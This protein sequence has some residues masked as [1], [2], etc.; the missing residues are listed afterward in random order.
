MKIKSIILD[1]R[2]KCLSVC[3]KM[4][5]FFITNLTK[6]R[7]KLYHK[8]SILRIQAMP[9]INWSYENTP[10]TGFIAQT[11]A[12]VVPSAVAVTPPS[13]P[14]TIQPRVTTLQSNCISIRGEN[15][16]LLTITNKGD[17]IWHGKPSE[18]SSILIRNCTFKVED[19]I[20]VTKA[21]RRRYYYLACRSLLK[22][23]QKMDGKE[24]ID[25][26]EKEVYNREGK[27]MWDALTN[28]HKN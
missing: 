5:S 7:T 15:K 23:A 1:S 6:L 19:Q 26:L 12:S 14:W 17:V 9:V 2:I 8:K 10:S 22:K 24:F 11:V 27:V 13:G 16:E 20:G 18:A 25:H 4:I 21:A 3:L 28:E